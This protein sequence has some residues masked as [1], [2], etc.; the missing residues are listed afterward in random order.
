MKGFLEKSIKKAVHFIH[1]LHFYNK[2]SVQQKSV[3]KFSIIVHNGSSSNN[4]SIMTSGSSTFLEIG[5][6]RKPAVSN[7]RQ[8]LLCI[9]KNSNEYNPKNFNQQ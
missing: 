7:F 1:L 3:S 8:I 9:P 2:R 5:V 6:S 4:G